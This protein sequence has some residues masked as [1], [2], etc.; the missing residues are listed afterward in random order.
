MDVSAADGTLT[1]PRLVPHKPPFAF[2]ALSSGSSQKSQGF[3]PTIRIEFTLRHVIGSEVE[4][5]T[6]GEG[7]GASGY[8]LKPNKAALTQKQV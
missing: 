8:A 7:S 6:P 3:S 1:S 5:A 2:S 4:I